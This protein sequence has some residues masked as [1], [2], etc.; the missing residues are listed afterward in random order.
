MKLSRRDFIGLTLSSG[1]FALYNNQIFAN[2]NF[3]IK[4]Q[5]V[6]VLI[7]MRGGNDGLNTIIP[8]RNSIYF[9]QRP[10]ISIKNS[11]K[12][13]KELALNPSMES[14]LPLWEENKL[15][16]VL[17]VGW[18]NPNRS[19]FMAMDQWSTGSESGIGK[20][21]LA[22]I[23]D[24]IKNEKYLL[25]LGPTGSNAIEGSKVNSLHFLG[26]E[27]KLLKNKNYEKIEIADNRKSLKRFLE[28]EEFSSQKLIELKN[29]IKKLPLDIKLPNG[30]LSKQVST[31]LK[32]INTDFPPSFI[33]MELGGFD[34]HQNQISRQNRLLKEL[35]ENVSALKRFTEKL[36]ENVELNIVITSEFG[37]RLKENGSKGT[38]HGSASI[39]FLI[40]D[41]FKEKFI[42]RYPDLKN[43][44][45][46]GDLIPNLYPNDLYG[47]IQNKIW[48]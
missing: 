8:Y 9:S 12:L 43:L 18:P 38:D 45:K 13:N 44:D 15:S 2:S 23:S 19:H 21:W 40:G 7:E 14:L 24:F 3:G 16:F 32:I 48:G 35:S 20:G 10:N 27:K 22:K 6:L 28:I 31:A 25:S 26:N 39:A 41:V 4:K 30:Q 42:G 34:T 29:K 11:L 47:Y 46:R 1:V 5:K 37:R 17:G 33:Q 36:N